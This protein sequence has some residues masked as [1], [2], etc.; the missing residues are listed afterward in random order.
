M[1]T[2]G[3]KYRTLA[4]RILDGH[5]ALQLL[6]LRSVRMASRRLGV[7]ATNDIF[8]RISVIYDFDYFYVTVVNIAI[9]IDD[10]NFIVAIL[11]FNINF[12]L[13]IL[14]GLLSNSISS[15]PMHRTDGRRNLGT[16]CKRCE[17]ISGI[18]CFRNNG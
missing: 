1:H 14:S 3:R 15:L 17:G 8:A 13:S 4:L 10:H 16:P 18:P 5:F 9:V 11:D 2:P 6:A 7:F 12:R